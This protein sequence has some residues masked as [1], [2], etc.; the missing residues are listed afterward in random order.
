VLTHTRTRTRSV[1]SIL[2]LFALIATLLPT[3]SVSA[4]EQVVVIPKE[5]MQVSLLQSLWQR[6]RDENER[7]PQRQVENLLANELLYD[8]TNDPNIM[9]AIEKFRTEYRKAMQP[10]A[11]PSYE[12]SVYIGL[13]QVAAIPELRYT[14]LNFGK[15]FLQPNRKD[16]PFIDTEARWEIATGTADFYQQEL[17][18]QEAAQTRKVVKKAKQDPQFAER[19]DQVNKQRLGASITELDDV[20][21][22]IRDHPDA[23]IPPKI[24]ESMRADG[25]VA[26]SLKDLNEL[27]RTEF[28]KI[29]ASIDD[30]QTTVD[31]INAKQDVLLDYVLDERERRAAQELAEAKAQEHRLK[32]QIA[33]S[34]VN[35]ISTLAGYIDPERGKQISVVGSSLIQVADA[36]ASWTKAVA[37]LGT[38]DALTSLSTAAMTGN[39]I[40]AVLNVVSLFGPSQPTPEQMILEQIGKLRQ[41]VSELRVEMHDRFDRVDAQLNTIYT[42]MQDRFDKIDLRLGKI[43]GNVQEIQ[44]TLVRLD[45]TLSRIER[46]SFE[47]LD[48]TNRRPLLNAINGGLGYQERTGRVMPYQPDFLA[49]ENDFHSWGTLFAYDA[50]SAGPTERDYSD[51]AVLAELNAYPLDVNINYLNGWLQAH[52]MQPFANKRLPGPRDWL[53]ASRAYA[54]LGLEWP[55]HAS[56]IKPERQ[57]A[58]DAVGRDLEQAMQNISTRL[59]PDGPQGNA[60]LF[61]EVISYYTEQLEGFDAGLQATEAAFVR[62]Q[63]GALGRSATFDLYGGVDQQLQHTPAEMITMT[64]DN[65]PVYV[66]VPAPINLKNGVPNYTRTVLADYL[67]AKTLK[68][69]VGGQWQDIR[70]MCSGTSCFDMALHR[71]YIFIFVGNTVVAQ[72]YMDAAEREVIHGEAF[73][74]T[75]EGWQQPPFYKSLFETR[76]ANATPPAASDAEITKS[77]EDELSRLQQAFHGRVKSEMSAGNLRN[78]ALKL[79]GAKKLLESFVALGMPQALERDDLLRSLLYSNQALV[80][81]QQVF[82]AY[83]RPISSTLGATAAISPTDLPVN[84]RVAVMATA[85][86][87]HEALGALLTR[88]TDAINAQTYSEPISLIGD[89]RLRMNLSMTLAGI[90]VGEPP[91]PGEPGGPNGR[92]RLFLP[93]VGH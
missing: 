71:A 29:N 57:A 25:S 6:A 7:L 15:T 91:P 9:N 55:E 62:E 38:L 58:L 11:S 52:G 76:F 14:L 90:A 85:K 82:A 72:H 65:H 37:G 48:A 36:Y 54:Q 12:A 49:Y 27:A 56:Q 64:C 3:H 74:R 22:F 43:D 28:G 41:Q 75:A 5:E 81:D 4:E 66:H 51:A 8:A 86:Q 73:A 84:P 77:I 21:T 19:Y 20:G 42:T 33:G 92:R 44:Q 45:Q 60:P 87:R 30:L 17:R 23:A 89:T 93:L 67:K 80:D 10:F 53:F 83:T 26:I 2:L 61:T 13:T 34:A 70:R 39:V 63:A 35:I 69:C 18:K 47:F 24:L 1:A 50:L 68:A 46:N 79:A 16:Y 40:G 32:L 59:T 31:S 88:Y 78:E